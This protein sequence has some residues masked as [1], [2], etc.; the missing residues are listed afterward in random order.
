MCSW[1]LVSQPS[2]SRLAAVARSTGVLLIERVAA[3]IRSGPL[4]C[5]MPARHDARTGTRVT[6]RAAPGFCLTKMRSAAKPQRQIS[7]KH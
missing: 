2:L 7:L 1:L 6:G 3:E 4:F 5:P